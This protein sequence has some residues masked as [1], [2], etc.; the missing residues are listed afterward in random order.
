MS[1]KEDRA[2]EAAVRHCETLT[3]QRPA[4]LWTAEYRRYWDA[5]MAD[6]DDIRHRPGLKTQLRRRMGKVRPTDAP[7]PAPV[8]QQFQPEGVEAEA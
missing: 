4:W 5:T 7:L 6:I 3:T 1:I 8:G 2:T